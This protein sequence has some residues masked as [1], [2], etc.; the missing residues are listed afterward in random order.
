MFEILFLLSLMIPPAQKRE[1][2]VNYSEKPPSLVQSIIR[3]LSIVVYASKITIIFFFG[4][5]NH[6]ILFL[7]ILVIV[8]ANLTSNAVISKGLSKGIDF[9]NDYRPYLYWQVSSI[10]ISIIILSK[11]LIYKHKKILYIT[12][13][14]ASGLC[15]DSIIS[16]AKRRFQW[17][18]LGLICPSLISKIFSSIFIY[19]IVHIGWLAYHLWRNITS[20]QTA[21]NIKEMKC[22]RQQD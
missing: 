2:L 11:S 16:L 19:S 17:Q 21:W 12:S 8:C 4:N 7:Y 14:H 20:G 1:P 22:E 6:G 3:A 5:T 13:H 15:L 9:C 18:S 10:L